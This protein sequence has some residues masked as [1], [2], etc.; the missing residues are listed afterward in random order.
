MAKGDSKLDVQKIHMREGDRGSIC[1]P[2]KL[3]LKYG[4]ENNV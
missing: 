3:N 2:V 4:S 1:N